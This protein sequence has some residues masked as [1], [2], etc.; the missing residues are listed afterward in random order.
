M[1]LRSSA[2][3]MAMA[4]VFPA[5]AV[6]Q[7]TPVVG[8]DA[9][10]SV[11]NFKLPFSSLASPE[12]RAL[13]KRMARDPFPFAEFA[14]KGIDQLRRA[15][16]ERYIVP[17]LARMQARYPATVE[18]SVLGGVPVQIV[19]PQSGIPSRNRK[20]ILINLH[21]GGFVLG[22]RTQS[23]VE[24]IPFAVVGEIEVVSVDYRLA[25][26]HRWPAANEDLNAVYKA[27][28]KTHRPSDI[29]IYGC[30]AGG[31]LTAQS[32][33][34]FAQAKLPLPAALGIFCSSTRETSFGDSAYI[35]PALGSIL[36]APAPGD[37]GLGPYFSTADTSSPLV[38]P[39]LAKSLLG[40]FPPTILISGTRAS[41]MSAITRSHIDLVQAGV[42]ARMFLWDGMDHGFLSEA[43]LPESREVYRIATEF[44]H[45]A[46]ARGGGRTATLQQH[47]TR[48]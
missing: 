30:S 15:M 41:E 11:P 14:A 45:E 22:A 4:L 29:A 17:Q 39:S 26:E 38:I 9:T 48:R 31:L 20:R 43:D 36:P 33:G 8:P 19:R 28:L 44:F 3:C 23:L 25:P 24:S 2:M 27:L 34:W 21:G 5:H 7:S 18:D 6:A 16:D 35:T 37:N 32:V 46:M 1:G 40:R 12:A 10:V 42:D 47:R 13:R